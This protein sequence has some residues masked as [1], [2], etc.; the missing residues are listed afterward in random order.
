M[1][2]QLASDRLPPKAGMY[3]VTC[4]Y[5]DSGERF[6]DVSIWEDRWEI[7]ALGNDFV[8]S[9]AIVAWCEFPSPWHD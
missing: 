4:E 1:N 2:W 9:F 6:T 5:Q 8:R 3:L 7:N